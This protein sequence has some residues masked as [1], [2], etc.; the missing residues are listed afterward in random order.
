MSK[1]T[2]NDVVETVDTSIETSAPIV[3]NEP[4]AYLVKKEDGYHIE[5]LDG[6]LSDV[7]AVHKSGALTLTPNAANRQW[8]M[9]KKAD[10]I[11]AENGEDYKIPLTFKA[12]RTID[13]TSRSNKLPNEKLI[14]YLPEAEQ[15]EYKAI[16]ARAIAARDAERAANKKRP[17]TESEKAQA[18]VAAVIAKLKE[19]GVS[20]ADIKSLIENNAD[21]TAD[22]NTEGGNN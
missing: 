12:T 1:T 13:G 6:N 7:L 20:E 16:I 9:L 19:L 4:K 2:K 3:D 11:I 17:M 14:S 5:D 15:E 18:K 8:F 10:S 22:T 21:T